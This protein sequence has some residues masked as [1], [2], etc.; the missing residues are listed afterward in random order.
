VTFDGVMSYQSAYAD[1]W[2]STGANIDGAN[3]L[4]Y[5]EE[6]LYPVYTILKSNGFQVRCVK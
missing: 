1:Y 4:G 5:T 2:S 6:L 3:F